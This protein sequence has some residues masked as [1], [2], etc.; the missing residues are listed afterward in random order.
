[1]KKQ[2][3]TRLRTHDIQG[4]S[5]RE[6][7]SFVFSDRKSFYR[8]YKLHHNADKEEVKER[9]HTVLNFINPK[10]LLNEIRLCFSAAILME[11]RQTYHFNLFIIDL[12]ER[13]YSDAIYSFKKKDIGTQ[14]QINDEEIPISYEWVLYARLL[15][16]YQ[17]Y[18]LFE[19][20]VLGYTLEDLGKRRYCTSRTIVN[21]LNQIVT[22]L[23]EN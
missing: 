23:S 8:D 11:E 16:P 17:R 18:L 1:M 5:D 7:V 19:Y 3:E 21:H 4:M 9:V 6:L 22:D 20:L 13:Y 14:H 10:E 12:I 15:T 2:N